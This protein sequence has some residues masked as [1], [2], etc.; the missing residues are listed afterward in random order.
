MATIE[1]IVNDSGYPLQIRLEEWIKETWK[2]HH[3][4]VATSE[5]RWVNKQTQE[6]GYI[7][8]ILEQE[9]RGVKLII[10]CKRIA[11]TWTFLLPKEKARNTT[12]IMGLVVNHNQARFAW[13]K[14]Y[15]DPSSQE[16]SFC[17]FETG[18]KKDS[19]T[20]EKLSGELLLSLEYTAKEENHILQPIIS[21]F[22]SQNFTMSYIPVIVTTA[23][24]QG[25]K[26]EHPDIEIANGKITKSET[27][28]IQYIRFRKNLASSIRY[29]NTEVN[30][31]RDLNKLNDR[32][33]FVV[34][35]E[36]FIEFLRR[37]DFS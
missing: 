2:E 21:N 5:H 24:L 31:L 8:L 16:S 33:V 37:L 35:A 34:Q 25:M 12:D 23:N 36:S 29:D 7:D 6:E 4:E 19:R 13:Q 18:G 3:W 20:L 10:E 26:F 1:D 11:G 17:I 32:T 27:E 9:K 28:P 22:N 15:P 30:R 14:L